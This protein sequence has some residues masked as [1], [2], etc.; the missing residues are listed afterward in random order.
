[1]YRFILQGKKIYVF[2]KTDKEFRDKYGNAFEQIGVVK[3]RDSI[4]PVKEKLQKQ[5]RAEE[6]I[7]DCYL[8]RKCGWKYWSE[9]TKAMVRQKM[10]EAKRN[11]TLSEYQ[12]MRMS[13]A[14]KGQPNN[15]AGHKHSETTKN[16]QALRRKGVKTRQG[17]KWCHN[18][19][20]KQESAAYENALPEG[21]VWG[22]SPD[23]E[24]HKNFKSF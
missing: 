7:M 13:E 23:L 11:K 10:S 6:V 15:H 2:D 14:K 12:R 16:I 9:E 8:K 22:R 18:P 3:D 17:M 24:V 21:F 20:T 19:I 4:D 1:M 5:Y